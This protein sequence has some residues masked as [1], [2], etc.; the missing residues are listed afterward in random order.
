MGPKMGP[1]AGRFG[2][3]RL[4]AFFTKHA[5]FVIFR[6]RFLHGV[7]EVLGCLLGGSWVS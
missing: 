1:G 3:R 6:G 5:F 7:L 2:D 4:K